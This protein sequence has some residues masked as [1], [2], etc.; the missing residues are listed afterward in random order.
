VSTDSSAAGHASL[1]GGPV[2]SGAIHGG[3]INGGASAS[4]VPASRPE[5]PTPPPPSAIPPDD[6]YGM[7]LFRNRP[8]AGCIYEPARDF[9]A[10]YCSACHSS[11][12]SNR[13]SQRA[14][15]ALLLDTYSQWLAASVKIPRRLDRDSLLGKIMPPLTF[16]DQPGNAERRAVVDWLRRGSPNT[17]DGR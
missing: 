11:Q 14:A 1:D 16:P 3:A 8:L 6:R 2:D 10:R 5:N 17:P 4:A 12:A 13:I 15:E 9:V 7:V